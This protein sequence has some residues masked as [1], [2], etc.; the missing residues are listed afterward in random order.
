MSGHSKW[1]TIH[2]K[3]GELDAAR[4][5]VFQ[6]I[7]K[8]ASEQSHRTL[9]PE[10]LGVYDINNIPHDLLADLNLLAYEKEAG[11]TSDFINKDAKSISV[12]I[13]PEGG[14]S[15][16]EVAKLVKDGFKLISLGKRIL[17][18]ETAAVYALSV[19]SYL[20]EK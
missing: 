18:T 2:R 12:M 1:A 14:F 5:K 17:R 6:K 8:E 4:G 15:D 10:V 20:L 16:E 19:I 3:K 13:G 9:I 7:A 11:Q